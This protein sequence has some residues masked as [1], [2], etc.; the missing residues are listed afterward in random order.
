M[1]NLTTEYLQEKFAEYN[2]LYFDNI[3]SKCKIYLYKDKQQFGLYKPN[4]IQIINNANW[5]EEYLREVLIHE[6]IHHY[7]Y[8]IEKKKGGL[9]GHN[10]R[11]KRQCRRIKKEFGINIH[12]FSPKKLKHI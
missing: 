8:T 4:K 6:M 9:F 7:I 11:F 2:H 5:T 3:L 12:I 10:W 1:I